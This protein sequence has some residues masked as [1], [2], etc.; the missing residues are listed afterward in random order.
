MLAGVTP[1]GPRLWLRQHEGGLLWGGVYLGHPRDAPIDAEPL[2]ERFDALPD[3]GVRACERVAAAATTSM[4]ALKSLRTTR[5]DHGAP[6]YTPDSRALVGAVPGIDG[7][8]ALV[9]DND[10]GITHGPGFAKA[11]ADDDIAGGGSELTTLDAW[12]LDRFDGAY[13]SEREVVASLHSAGRRD[14][15][16]TSALAGR[17]SR[18][19]PPADPSSVRSLV[20]SD[21]RGRGP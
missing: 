19:K 15:R 1:H 2:P 11:L 20:C 8:Y 6:C 21:F 10:A 7:L 13:A 12:R 4:P 9:G 14:P 16:R 3:D 17:V 5:V 18:L